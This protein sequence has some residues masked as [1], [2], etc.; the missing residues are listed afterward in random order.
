MFLSQQ[1]R[2]WSICADKFSSITKWHIAYR[3]VTVRIGYGCQQ[4][5]SE[6]ADSGSKMSSL[7]PGTSCVCLD[8]IHEITPHCSLAPMETGVLQNGTHL[9]QIVSETPVTPPI[10]TVSLFP[11]SFHLRW[12]IP[13]TPTPTRTH[14]TVSG[15]PESRDEVTPDWWIWAGSDGI[16]AMNLH[17][18]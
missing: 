7:F 2:Q 12:T 17:C 8:F 5:G 16:A 3:C 4:L 14:T 10:P 6:M 15:T 11:P 9:S 18:S 1:I 13:H